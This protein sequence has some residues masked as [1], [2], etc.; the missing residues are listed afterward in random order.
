MLKFGTREYAEII[1][2]WKAK[3]SIDFGLGKLY[4]C[5]SSFLLI[6]LFSLILQMIEASFFSPQSTLA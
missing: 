2:Y 4:V 1:L 5:L 6:S 3:K